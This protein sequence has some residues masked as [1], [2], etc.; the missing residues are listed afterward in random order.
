M[1]VV[2]V[3]TDVSNTPIDELDIG[4]FN[5]SSAGFKFRVWNNPNDKP[6]IVSMTGVLISLYGPSLPATQK[7]ILDA[8][9]LGRCT[10]SAKLDGVVS[11]SF[12]AFPL[13]DTTYDEIPSNKYNEYEVKVD[14]SG[15]S[16]LQKTSIEDQDI[17]TAIVPRCSEIGR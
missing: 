7:L 17:E 8:K 15:Y 6:G 10:Y 3:V 16:D 11:E 1:A 4:S 12:K 5:E 14:Y 2:I 9:I 13:E